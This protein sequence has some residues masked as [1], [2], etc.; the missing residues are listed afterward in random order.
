VAQD[1][2]V[3][4]ALASQKVRAHL[5]GRDVTKVIAKPPRLLSLVAARD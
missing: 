1:E 5:G 2:M 4:M 3:S